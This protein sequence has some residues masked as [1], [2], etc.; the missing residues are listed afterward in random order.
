MTRWGGRLQVDTHA[1]NLGNTLL[2]RRGGVLHGAV[3]VGE[4]LKLA[5]AAGAKLHRPHL[6]TCP[7]ADRWR[8]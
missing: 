6:Q 5:R 4:P 2:L 1:S 3:L 8:H 7:Q